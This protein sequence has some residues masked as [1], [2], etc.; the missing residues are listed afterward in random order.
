MQNGDGRNHPQ[1]PSHPKEP[2][3]KLL[4]SFFFF[5]NFWTCE[6]G[7]SH[8]H[9]LFGGGSTTRKGHGDSSTTLESAMWV[10]QPLLFFSI[11]FKFLLFLFFSFLFLFLIRHRT[12]VSFLKALM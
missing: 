7:F 5:K 3:P 4:T 2:N 10:T 11:F 8:L 12:H 9:F 1:K 6:G